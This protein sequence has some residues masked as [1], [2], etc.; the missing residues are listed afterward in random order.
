[1]VLGEPGTGKSV[2]RT[3]VQTHDPKRLIAPV[4]SRTLH[5]Y[6]NVL[7][8]L[9]QAVDLDT[10]GSDYLCFS[11]FLSYSSVIFDRVDIVTSYL[12]TA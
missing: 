12:H 10:D 6:H 5:T 3:A 8:I 11:T 4:V 1:M 9:C 2:L 7:R